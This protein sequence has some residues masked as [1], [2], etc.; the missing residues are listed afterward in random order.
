MNFS[1]RGAIKMNEFSR[2]EAIIGSEH[3]ARLQNSSVAVIGL[4]GVGSWAAE[5]LAR[6]GVGKMLLI[7]GD[8]VDPTNINRQLYALHSTIGQSKAELAAARIRDI[9]P[10]CTVAAVNGFYTPDNAESF[11]LKAYDCVIDAIDMVTAKIELAVR[12]Q[13]EGFALLSAMGTGN[14]LDP[15]RFQIADI[16]ETRVCPLCR[17]MRREL[18]KRGVERLRVLYSEEEPIRP[19]GTGGAPGSIAFVPPVAGLLLAREAAKLI[20]GFGS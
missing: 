19:A 12:A 11:E 17:V 10:S 18:K 6:C 14:K 5:A 3:T 15:T 4:G 1:G 7:D 13:A 9:N 20:C 2:M 16:Y 8:T